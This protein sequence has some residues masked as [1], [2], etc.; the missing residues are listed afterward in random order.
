MK[1]VLLVED[2]PDDA[3]M[4]QNACRS[5][6]IPHV[7]VHLLDGVEAIDYLAAAAGDP[8]RAAHPAVDLM[9]LDIKLPRKDGHE[10]LAWIRAQPAFRSLPVIMLTNSDD[11]ND[12]RRAYKLGVTSYL[13]KTGDPAGLVLGVRIILKY[14]LSLN[15][16][17]APPQRLVTS[18]L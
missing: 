4:M 1:T 14:W 18:Y 8:D 10:V 5:A 6:D 15:V 13:L 17:P 16:M 12:V 7:L 9:F 11:P 3:L 2:S